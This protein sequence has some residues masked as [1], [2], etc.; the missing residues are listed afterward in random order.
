MRAVVNLVGVEDQRHNKS[1]VKGV[2]LLKQE[3]PEGG[4]TIIGNV[5]GLNPG[6][7]H[8]I[9]VHEFGDLRGGCGAGRTGHHFNPYSVMR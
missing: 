7:K 2:I 4:L 3:T 5:S 6:Q 8:G 9:H 1:E